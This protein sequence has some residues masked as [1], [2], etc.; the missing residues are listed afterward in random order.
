[1]TVHSFIVRIIRCLAA[2]F[3]K[4]NPDTLVL[5]LTVWVVDTNK[6]IKHMAMLL[7]FFGGFMAFSIAI[8]V[9]FARGNS[10]LLNIR[11]SG[12]HENSI[13]FSKISIALSDC[14]DEL[15]NKDYYYT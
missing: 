15:H 9:I 11:H 2:T 5:Y 8:N 3:L 13:G 1:M 10:S 7:D 12:Q 6:I 14:K 4:I